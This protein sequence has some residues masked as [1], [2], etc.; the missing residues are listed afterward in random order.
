MRPIQSFTYAMA[1][2]AALIGVRP[3]ANSWMGRIPPK[4]TDPKKQAAR[5]RQRKARAQNRKK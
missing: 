4:I 1:A 5:K 2:A 3:S